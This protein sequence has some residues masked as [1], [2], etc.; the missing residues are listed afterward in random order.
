MK[1]M[2]TLGKLFDGI[3]GLLLLFM[4]IKFLIDGKFIESALF[5]M[6]ESIH[7]I[8]MFFA[9]ILELIIR[10]NSKDDNRK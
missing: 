6:A 9:S 1:V 2:L 8:D 10:L 7:A 4:A 5:F 3:I